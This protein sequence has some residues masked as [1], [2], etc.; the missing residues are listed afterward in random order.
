MDVSRH[1]DY[2]FRVLMYLAL[3]GHE[4]SQIK[5]IADAFAI[6][7]HHL[8]KIVQNLVKFGYI[9]SFR[10]RH[11][12][13]KLAM[14]PAKINLGQVFRRTEASLRLLTCFDAEKNECVIAGYCDLQTVFQSALQAFL[15]VMD[16]VTLDDVIANRKP[17]LKILKISG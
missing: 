4:L 11:G 16:S 10:G 12:G 13:I 17:L 5:N 3:Q 9:E 7:E 8:I 6:S 1:S 2:S 14:E 15:R